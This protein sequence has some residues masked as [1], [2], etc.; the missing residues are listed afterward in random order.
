M[1]IYRWFKE[2]E[3]ISDDWNDSDEEQAVGG[4]QGPQGPGNV[5]ISNQMQPADAH[6]MNQG[7][8]QENPFA[9]QPGNLSGMPADG[10]G[11]SA[12]RSVL[13]QHNAEFENYQNMQLQ[14]TRPQ[15]ETISQRSKDADGFLPPKS[16][17]DPR[18]IT[19]P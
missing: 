1:A 15:N 4:G 12:Q 13:Q 8:L 9:K 2:A 17:I 3:G 18:S 11:L 7:M 6:Q 19:N 10:G 5:G 14:K 16:I